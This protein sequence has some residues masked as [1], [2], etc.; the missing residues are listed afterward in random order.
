MIEKPKGMGSGTIPYG[1]AYLEGELVKNP[2]EYKTVLRIMALWKSGK[3]LNGIADI[4]NQKPIPT[5]SGGKWVHSVIA[6]IIKKHQP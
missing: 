2:V 6:G 1:Y 5:R 3:S 4:L